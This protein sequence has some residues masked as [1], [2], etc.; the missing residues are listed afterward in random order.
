MCMGVSGLSLIAGGGNKDRQVGFPQKIRHCWR[1]PEGQR[2]GLTAA[3]HA[4]TAMESGH[5]Y[6][7][8]GMNSRLNRGYNGQGS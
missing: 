6:G 3:V 7:G 2:R 4:L 5:V 8:V 1:G